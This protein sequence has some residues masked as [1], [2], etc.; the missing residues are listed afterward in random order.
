MEVVSFQYNQDPETRLGEG[1]SRT[2]EKRARLFELKIWM[3]GQGAMRDLIKATSVTQAVQFAKNR[4]PNCEIEVPEESVKPRLA[5]SQSGARESARRRNKL[6]E[7]K[8]EQSN[9]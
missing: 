6:V 8:R 3:P 1:I 4:Y 2:S 7:T 5:R 9:S